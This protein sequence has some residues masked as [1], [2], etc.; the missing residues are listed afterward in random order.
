MIERKPGKRLKDK[1]DKAERIL[2]LRH[3]KSKAQ[4]EA[5]NAGRKSEAKGG[6]Y[7]PGPV[8]PAAPTAYQVFSAS[9]ISGL[10]FG[11]PFISISDIHISAPFPDIAQHVMKTERIGQET[12]YR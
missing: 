8:T 11:V 5:S 7:A 10:G 4:A 1:E 6:T 3:N 9:L 2:L 12:A